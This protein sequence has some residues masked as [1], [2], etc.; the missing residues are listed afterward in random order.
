VTGTLEPEPPASPAD[1]DVG[2]ILLNGSVPVDPS[3]PTSIGDAD[4]D[5]RPD[6]TV[7]FDRAAVDLTVEEGDAVTVTAEG[8][9]GNGCFEATDV[10]RVIRAHISAPSPGSVVQ[11]GGQTEVRW[12]TPAGV[13][14]E[15]V[16]LLSSMDDGATWA[17]E[18]SQLPNSGSY[19]WAVPGTAAAHARIAVVLVESADESG[20]DVEGVLGTSEP[21]TIASPLAVGGTGVELALRGSVPNPSTGLSVSF[22][23]P[24]AKPATL[25]VY[26]IGGRE[27]SRREVGSLGAG[28]HVLMLQAPGTLAPGIYWVHLTHAEL[29]LVSRTVVAR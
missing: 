7:K 24:D 17:L 9:I 20:V 8:K 13:Q 4:G 22:S 25:A 19:L 1:I 14:V 12:D 11:G 23:L 26:D 10:I 5:G 15:W 6:L 18:A 29:E 28:R 2:S 27:V 21:F 16:A 3:A